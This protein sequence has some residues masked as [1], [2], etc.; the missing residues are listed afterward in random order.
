M[1]TRQECLARLRAQVAAG[2]P[3]IGGLDI[4]STDYAFAGKI[5]KK[6]NSSGASATS[7]SATMA[8]ALDDWDPTEDVAP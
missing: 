5:Y 2:K 1:F 8:H 3:I 6:T 4:N 7:T